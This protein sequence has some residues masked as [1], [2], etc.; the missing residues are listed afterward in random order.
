MEAFEHVAKVFLE[1]QGYAVSTNV[2]FP[3][4]RRTRKKAYAE[5]QVHGYEVDL[6]AAKAE[7]LLLGSVKSFF[8]SQGV[9]RQHFKAIADPKGKRLW[10]ENKLFNEPDVQEGVLSEAAKQFGYPQ[11]R[12]FLG[13]FVGRFKPTDEDSIRKHLSR[14]KCGGGPV[15]IFDL[16]TILGGV[17]AAAKNDTYRDDPVIVVI[18][19]LHKLKWLS[20]DNGG[21]GQS[22]NR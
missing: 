21:Q 4:R 17:V 18:K 22:E 14:L 2:K 13:L 11:S 8:G 19:G 10:V 20:T 6:V 3:V 7:E 16:Q 15:L 5:Y 9:S 1:T 12:I